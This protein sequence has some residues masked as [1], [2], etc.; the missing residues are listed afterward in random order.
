M[1]LCLQVYNGSSFDVMTE[2]CDINMSSFRTRKFRSVLNFH[3]HAAFFASASLSSIVVV[4]LASSTIT[5]HK[6]IL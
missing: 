5:F 6:P 3:F 1:L 4:V 2:D